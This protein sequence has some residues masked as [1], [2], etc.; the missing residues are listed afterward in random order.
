[1]RSGNRRN[2]GSNDSFLE[3]VTSDISEDTEMNRSTDEQ[4]M[5]GTDLEQYFKGIKEKDLLTKKEEVSLARKVQEGDV[6]ARNEMVERNLR[7]VVSIARGYI[8]C[9]LDL[10]DLIQCGNVGLMK[11]VQMFDPEKGFKFST[12]ATWWIRQ[13]ILRE[14]CNTGRSIRLPVHVNEKVS[15]L[16]KL[17]GNMR[18]ELGRNPTHEEIANAYG[19]SVKEVLDLFSYMVA[20]D[21]LD[22]EI[23]D[24]DNPGVLGDL[25]ANENAIDPEEEVMQ[26]ML[27]EEIRE[28]IHTCLDDREAKILAARYELEGEEGKTLQELGDEF[29]LTRERIRQIQSV[30]EKKLRRYIRREKGLAYEM[31]IIT[32]GEENNSSRWAGMDDT[33]SL[34]AKKSRP[35]SKVSVNQYPAWRNP[36]AYDSIFCM[37]GR[38]STPRQVQAEPDETQ[39][40]DNMLN[41]IWNSLDPESMPLSTGVAG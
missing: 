41:E 25:V 13:S 39:I 30:A 8:G 40:I 37:E 16:K 23:N 4:E 15:K 20:M 11:A 3:F 29:S 35:Q 27:T 18:A 34:R 26:M 24:S 21:S 17:M 1:M 9:G 28:A 5:I 38:E 6:K 2:I 33:G 7:L 31:G 32:G 12:Y 22:K 36:L 14:I 19:I 10:D